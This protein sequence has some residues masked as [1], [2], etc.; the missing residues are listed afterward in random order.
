M[1]RIARTVLSMVLLLAMSSLAL[2]AQAAGTFIGGG[3]REAFNQKGFKNTY[4]CVS[5]SGGYFRGDAYTAGLPAACDYYEVRIVELR[6]TGGKEVAWTDPQPC[7]RRHSDVVL[8]ADRDELYT[9]VARMVVYSGDAR[10]GS[11]ESPRV[12]T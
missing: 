1:R 5:V 4:P 12:W 9:Y 2:P 8:Y 11:L 10:I 3:C 6:P 7:N